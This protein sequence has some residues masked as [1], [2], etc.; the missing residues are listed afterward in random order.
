MYLILTKDKREDT[1]WAKYT[2]D[3][4]AVCMALKEPGNHVYTLDSLKKITGM[5]VSYTEMFE[6]EEHE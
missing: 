3:E 2:E 6:G 1:L 4:H 5:E